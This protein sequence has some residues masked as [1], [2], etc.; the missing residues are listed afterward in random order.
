MFLNGKKDLQDGEMLHFPNSKKLNSD[1]ESDYLRS[2]KSSIKFPSFDQNHYAQLLIRTVTGSVYPSHRIGR[3][4]CFPRHPYNVEI[5][6]YG[7]DWPSIGHT[8][9]G[10]IRLEHLYN[11]LR[12]TAIEY[13]PGDFVELGVWRG[14]SS[15]FAAGIIKQMNM[16]RSIWVCDSFEGFEDKPW[17]GDSGRSK[18][19]PVAAVG[20]E[21]V[22]QNFQNYGLLDANV[23][24]LKGFFSES[25]PSSQISAI[26]VLK[27]DA[28]LYSNTSDILYNL[29]ERVSLM[30]FIIVDDWSIAQCKAAVT[31]FRAA[32]N[33]TDPMVPIDDT[34]MYWR[35]G[36]LIKVNSSRY[37]ELSGMRSK[38]VTTDLNNSKE[39][40]WNSDSELKDEICCN[41][42]D[43]D[44]LQGAKE[45]Y[46]Y[47]LKVAA[48]PLGGLHGSVPDWVPSDD[49]LVRNNAHPNE[50]IR[51]H[52]PGIYVFTLM[53]GPKSIVELGVRTGWS[54]RAFLA[55]ARETGA[56]MLGIDKDPSSRHVYST[57]MFGVQCYFIEGESTVSAGIFR[58][59]ASE[60]DFPAS[61]DV[62]F[63]HTTHI[64]EDTI[65]EL[66]LWEPLLS[67][68][69]AIILHDSNIEDQFV[70]KDGTS[71]KGWNNQRGVARAIHQFVGIHFDETQFFDSGVEPVGNGWRVSHDPTSC[72]LTILQRSYRAAKFIA[73]SKEKEEGTNDPNPEIFDEWS[74]PECTCTDQKC[75]CL[76]KGPY[77]Q[78]FQR[79][80]G[81]C[82]K[83]AWE[84]QI[85][86]APSD[87]LDGILHASNFEPIVDS[88][89]H[90]QAG[91]ES[92]EFEIPV[93]VISH[94]ADTDRRKQAEFVLS[95]AG[96]GSISYPRFITEED[97]DMNEMFSTGQLDASRLE[98]LRN[99]PWV[100][101]K[102]RKAI[103][104]IL[105]HV[106]SLEAGIGL[107]STLFGI[108]EDDVMLG[109]SSTG[110]RKQ[111]AEALSELPSSADVLY[112]EYC[113]E[114]CSM[115]DCNSSFAFIRRAVKPACTAAMIFTRKGAKKTLARIKN[116][117][118]ALDN[119]YAEL[120]FHGDLEAYLVTP[121]IFFQDGYYSNAFKFGERAIFMQTHRQFSII[122]KE[123]ASD[124]DMSVLQI[125]DTQESYEPQWHVLN[126]PSLDVM[127][128][129]A[130][131]R[132]EWRRLI[133][134]NESILK[135]YMLS[136]DG[137]SIGDQ[138][139]S[140]EVSTMDGSIQLTLGNSSDCLR[141]PSGCQ[142]ST[143]LFD[144]DGY[145]LGERIVH[146]KPRMFLNLFVSEKN[147][148][149]ILPYM[150]VIS[151]T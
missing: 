45:Q 16:K 49:V 133:G 62:L 34:S 29:Y 20:L 99:T 105:N 93:F 84:T 95:S 131:E 52:L 23:K 73:V 28:D 97:I 81:S 108:F 82:S 39:E 48:T 54:T 31:D 32:H 30:G 64:F 119:M 79:H 69:A 126:D 63:V 147:G 70:L 2:M 4:D 83:E 86:P 87:I 47:L 13:V 11:A 37:A 103:S 3:E 42:K 17:D 142:V 12:L 130:F 43:V 134:W 98:S 114:S 145:D 144:R 61:V 10:W 15:I 51:S 78:S 129:D 18:L 85:L 146:I 125:M 56:K 46:M 80:H 121:P 90:P 138:I 24:F 26:S 96:F 107:N 143:V 111:I 102:W 19:N 67:E 33:I 139:G 41:E 57:C 60:N 7:N 148:Q 117:F 115:L 36:S 150:K 116:I 120:I 25:L 35:K 40:L 137:K 68:K 104:L 66:S 106:Q 77:I 123:Q 140:S 94:P 89:V 8:M 65:Q 118:L 44:I 100:G 9:T 127:S 113:F 76:R 50:D 59:W 5:R 128:L 75:Q 74:P 88:Y 72:G 112:L 110:A 141:K 124:L 151:P 53:F 1:R 71:G 109:K 6:K 136:S 27:L 22:Q 122:C 92:P 132:L 55:A 58:D 21:E 38:H 91:S 14:G 101:P 149:K 135:Y